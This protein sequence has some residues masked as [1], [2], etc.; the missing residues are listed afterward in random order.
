MNS[1]HRLPPSSLLCVLLV[2][3]GCGRHDQASQAASEEAGVQQFSWESASEKLEAGMRE[4]E[5]VG[6][7]GEPNCRRTRE[8]EVSALYWMEDVGIRNPDSPLKSSGLVASF[9]DGVLVEWDV[10]RSQGQ[11]EMGQ[12]QVSAASVTV[13]T[14]EAQVGDKLRFE[15][16][17]LHPLIPADRISIRSGAP[18]AGVDYQA[19]PSIKINDIERIQE[20]RS[21]NSTNAVQLHLVLGSRGTA[22]LAAFSR[23]NVGVSFAVVAD[24]RFLSTAV[25]FSPIQDGNL[26]LTIRSN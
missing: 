26:R 21:N 19:K 8:A 18:A 13:P 20:H 14:S 1:V 11:S 24:G 17:S 5:V 23:D 10:I 16:F 7:L 3:C 9:A 4:E 22:E 12:E 15:E 25:L 6:L 2:I